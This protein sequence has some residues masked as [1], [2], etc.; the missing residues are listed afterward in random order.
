[1]STWS[2]KDAYFEDR[3]LVV[4]DLALALFRGELALFLGSGVSSAF[5]LP[6]WVALVRSC[7]RS[8]GL[9]PSAVEDKASFDNLTAAMGKVRDTVR[10]DSEYFKLIRDHLYADGARR[11]KWEPSPLFTSIGALLMGSRRGRVREVWTFNYDDVIEWYLHL[12]GL[13]SQVITETPC[14]LRDVD[15]VVYHP[16]GFLPFDSRLPPSREVVFDDRSYAKRG[17][18]KAQEWRDAVQVAL[19][20]KVFIAIGLSWTDQ[21]LRNL[22][23]DAAEANQDRPTAFWMFGPSVTDND[24]EDCLRHNVVPLRFD[25]F[26]EYGP[27]L[28]TICSEA[29]RHVETS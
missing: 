21:L 12:H 9:D 10:N 23:I 27:F 22:I 3:A 4:N 17:V 1:M 20:S 2:H 25:D 14:L 6:G 16:H 29:M 8:V 19:R 28:R 13:L 7:L 18:G 26:G 15:V 5:G 11:D 24:M